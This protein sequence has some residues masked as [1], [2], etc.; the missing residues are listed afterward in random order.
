MSALGLLTLVFIFGSTVL[1]VVSLSNLLKKEKDISRFTPY[2][3]DEEEHIEY[4]TNKKRKTNPLIVLLIIIGSITGFSIVYII[5]GVFNISLLGLAVGFIIPKLWAKSH[6]KKQLQLTYIQ[7]EQAAEVMASVL[8]SG[9]GIVDALVRAAD[10]VGNPLRDE[11]ILT[12]NEIKLGISNSV[13]FSNLAERVDIDELSILSMAI[14]LQEE[15]MAVNLSSLL[16]KMQENIRYKLAYQ[17]QIKAIT[18]G[19]RLAGW[20]VSALPF[21]T[22]FIMRMIM[23][24][25]IA[26][27]FTTTLG[28]VIFSGCS[29][30]IV[31]GII[32]LMKIADVSL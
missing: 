28:L 17:R 24:D 16:N 19:N 18:S 21:A 31:I 8:R 3:E 1:F 26:P 5:T 15:G 30:V 32:W 6:A 27:L 29:I 22:L 23:P 20:I 13:A 9:S 25:I 10:E 12:A 11:L 7:L 2:W 4:T 14:N